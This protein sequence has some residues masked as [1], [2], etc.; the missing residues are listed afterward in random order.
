MNTSKQTLPK[1]LDLEALRGALRIDLQS[2]TRLACARTGKA[3]GSIR[4]DG[5]GT[6]IV[7]KVAYPVHRVVF[8]LHN[9]Y[10]PYPLPVHHKDAVTKDNHPEL[11]EAV[12]NK[13]NS[14]QRLKNRDLCF[15]PPLVSIK[16]NGLMQ[17]RTRAH[18]D[19]P[20]RGRD[21]YLMPCRYA[22]LDDSSEWLN[23]A[24]EAAHA[25]LTE[26]NGP[27]SASLAGFYCQLPIEAVMG[28]DEGWP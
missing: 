17:C 2:P 25:W 4:S 15:L 5:Y 26:R 23:A 20:G 9:G 22:H 8:A 6:V 3:R 12:T 28:P 19:S 7:N 24:S 16:A 11:L 13:V 27:D 14:Q 21:V 18:S 10:D 1:R